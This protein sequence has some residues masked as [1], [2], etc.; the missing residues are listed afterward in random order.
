MSN[1]TTTFIRI[2]SARDQLNLAALLCQSLLTNNACALD[3][4]Q[5]ER[6]AK[7]FDSILEV[8]QWFQV[9]Q[10]TIESEFLT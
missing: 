1:P 5:A 2:Q 10:N 6:L 4:K 3:A 7:A 9:W 8:E